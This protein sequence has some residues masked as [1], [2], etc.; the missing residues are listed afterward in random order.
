MG[1]AW[2][3]VYKVN[4]L[5]AID[6]DSFQVNLVI[7]IHRTAKNVERFVRGRISFSEGMPECIRSGHARE[8]LGRVMTCL[9]KVFGYVN[10]SM[11]SIWATRNPVI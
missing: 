2:R 7:M 5:G 9:A 11:G 3:A 4:I 10:T 6:L 1:Y 8:L